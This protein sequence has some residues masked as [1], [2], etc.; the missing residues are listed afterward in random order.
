M[1]DGVRMMSYIE[2]FDGGKEREIGLFEK[3][4]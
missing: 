2:E 3:S 4:N 1:M